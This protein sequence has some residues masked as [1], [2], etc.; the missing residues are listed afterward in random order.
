MPG[1]SRF[2][3]YLKTRQGVISLL[4]VVTCGLVLGFFIGRTY[5]DPPPKVYPLDFGKA[6]W[7]EAAKPS[8]CNYFRKDIYI[9]GQIDRGWLEIAA[10]DNYS[11]YVNDH[12]LDVRNFYGINVAGIYDLKKI[13]KVGKNTIAVSVS[14]ISFPGSAEVMVRGFYGVQGSPLQEFVSDGTWRA[15]N[16]PDGL[17]GVYPWHTTRLD[18]TFWSFAKE[19]SKEG[20]FAGIELVTLDPRLLETV[21]AGK[22]IAPSETAARQAS[23]LDKIQLPA[24]RQET[25]LQLAAT[26]NYDL[27]I[28][29]RLV[30]TQSFSTFSLAHTPASQPFSPEEISGG[31]VQSEQPAVQA[32]DGAASPPI[33]STAPLLL[34]YDLSRWLHT[35]ENTILVRVHS[36]TQ[37]ATLLVDGYTVLPKG[38]TKR[39]GTNGSWQSILSGREQAPALTVADYGA[40]PWSELQQFPAGAVINPSYDFQMGLTWALVILGVEIGLLL[41]WVI[42]PRLAGAILRY[43]AERLWT[44]SAVFHLCVL[45]VI[46][47]CW[48]L[49]FDVRFRSNWCYEPRFILGFAVLL[50]I[51]YL[52][53]FL[54]RFRPRTPPDQEQTEN[55]QATTAN[56]KAPTASRRR[57]LWI[58]AIAGVVVLGFF[59][60]VHGL[61][62]MSLDVDEMGVI[63]F[64][65][66]IQKRGYPFIQIGTFERE[67]TTYELVSYSIATARQ[68]LGETEAAC[69]TPSLIYSTLTIALMA[70]AGSRMMGWRVGLISALVYALFPAGLYWARNAFWPSQDQFFALLSIWCFYEATRPG[71][72]RRGFLTVSTI[73]FC[74]AYLTWEGSGFLLPAFFAC[75]FVRRWG[76]YS[77]MKDWH[78]WRC[79]VFMSF[80]VLIQLAHRQVA[81]LPIFLQTGNSL[82][83]VTTPQLVPLDLT[84]FNPFY[85]F[86]WI[87]FA[88]NY[89][90]MTILCIL[91]ILF[92]WRNSAIRYLFVLTA[93]LI[94][95][96][97]EFLPAYAVRYSY[98]YQ[99]TLILLAVGILFKLWDAITGLDEKWLKW[100]AATALVAL[101]L[102]S[103]NGFI[104]KTYR[105]SSN[106]TEAF[107]GERMGLY[108]ADARTP[109]RFVATHLREGDGLII[110]IPHM[111]EYYSGLKGDYSI[112]TMLNNK[113]TYDGTITVPHYIDKFRGYPVIRGIEELEDLRTRYKRL[114]IV[115]TGATWSNPAVEQY[116]NQNSRVVCQSYRSMVNL[117]GGQS[118]VSRQ[119]F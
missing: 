92:C 49:S 41:L 51:G 63:Q 62:T 86:Y 76:E 119:S 74:L 65:H 116:F 24:N 72:L 99:A 83:E 94:V 32:L 52:A 108:R 110:A 21:P 107:Y 11:L 73:G 109:A 5:F 80:V 50:G 48:L 3:S 39:F 112:N 93:L 53:S 4:L 29:G 25:W 87:L 104:L 47:F 44:S 58:I 103:T 36:S 82:S 70:L 98:D 55:G 102:L 23:F 13:L 45:A 78:L 89:C 77:W 97:T 7:L 81:S 101:F 105:L 6:Q 17:L 1:Q 59:L 10:T 15:S 14:R 26:G 31:V 16:T 96:Y 38:E 12:R 117:I 75:I 43:P 115:R 95:C 34:A 68:F 40:K 18:D 9:S 57:L 118:D 84:K 33:F 106:P 22:W 30:V 88:E 114:W 35:G 37:P 85:Y 8:P 90:G 100:C 113:I 20:R 27:V 66:G 54:P 56:S 42:V 71:P 91:G 111:F 60:R 19:G 67:V 79:C 61:G 28:N 64:S 2:L 69:R 46:L